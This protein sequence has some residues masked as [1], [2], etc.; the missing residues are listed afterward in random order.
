MCVCGVPTTTVQVGR[1]SADWDSN[2]SNTN[3]P[4]P[5]PP[6]EKYTQIHERYPPKGWG[7]PSPDAAHEERE[8]WIRGKYEHKVRSVYI[9]ICIFIYFIMYMVVG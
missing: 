4:S 8:A 7:K 9:Y 6:F 2:D 5:S 3:P 1:S